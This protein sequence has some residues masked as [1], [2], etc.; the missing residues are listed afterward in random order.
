MANDEKG[1]DAKP[2]NLAERKANYLPT[3]EAIKLWQETEKLKDE[4]VK[5]LKGEG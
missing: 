2:S 1:E 3:I 5:R 4:M